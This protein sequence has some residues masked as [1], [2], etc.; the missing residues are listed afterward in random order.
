[1]CYVAGSPCLRHDH[2]SQ[3][4]SL[5]PPLSTVGTKRPAH[6]AEALLAGI[7]WNAHSLCISSLKILHSSYVSKQSYYIQIDFSEFS[8]KM[9]AKA[10]Y[11]KPT[12]FYKALWAELTPCVRNPECIRWGPSAQGSHSFVGSRPIS[13]L[14]WLGVMGTGVDAVNRVLWGC[15]ELLTSSWRSREASQQS[16]FGRVSTVSPGALSWLAPHAW[17]REC[18]LP[19]G[20]GCVCAQAHAWVCV[21]WCMWQMDVCAWQLGQEEMELRGAHWSALGAIK[22]SRL[23]RDFILLSVDQENVFKQSRCAGSHTAVPAVRVEDESPDSKEGWWA[24]VV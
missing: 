11:R 2:Y 21:C 3:Q 23:Y 18:R 8:A 17:T 4:Q 22:P 15:R 1:M 6:I 20:R 13:H 24:S 10:P 16:D 12:L 9:K 5:S 14:V 7:L 19:S